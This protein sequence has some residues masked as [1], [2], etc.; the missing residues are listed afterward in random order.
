M[1]NL[2]F[3]QHDSTTYA[4]YDGNDRVVRVGVEALRRGAD[5]LRECLGARC[6]AL[7]TEIDERQRTVDELRYVMSH[8]DEVQW[9]TTDEID[10]LEHTELSGRIIGNPPKQMR[11]RLETELDAMSLDELHKLIAAQEDDPIPF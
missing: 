10:K 5:G 3:K 4:L 11:D 9:P 8:L 6:A 1:N 2:T 7:Q